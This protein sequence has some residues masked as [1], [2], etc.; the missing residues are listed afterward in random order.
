M[1]TLRVSMPN[2]HFNLLFIPCYITPPPRLTP[3]SPSIHPSIYGAT[4]ASGPWRPVTRRLYSSLSSAS[5]LHHLISRICDV[6][7]RTTSSHLVLG[8]PTSLLLWNFPLKTF[9]ADPFIFQSYN[10]SPCLYHPINIGTDYKL[11]CASLCSLIQVPLN[12]SIL[13]GFRCATTIFQGG[14]V[15]WPWN[16]A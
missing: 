2:I 9:I 4:A 11:S 5:L 7:L 8:L 10:T 1:Y 6:T 14:L 16:Y 15:D 13:A 12:F 3:L